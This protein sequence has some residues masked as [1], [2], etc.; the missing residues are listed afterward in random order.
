MPFVFS[1]FKNLFFLGTSIKVG[2]ILMKKVAYK[3]FL[4]KSIYKSGINVRNFLIRD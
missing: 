4:R 2:S 3:F 1:L